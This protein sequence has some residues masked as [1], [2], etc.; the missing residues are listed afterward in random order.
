[1][2][3]GRALLT[4]LAMATLAL[5]SGTTYTI[6]GIDDVTAPGYPE[7]AGT[8]A[9]G[10]NAS[11]Q[12]AGEVDAYDVDQT[13]LLRRGVRWS[14]GVTTPLDGFP[15]FTFNS[16]QG[17][18]DA[19][20][21]VGISG[22][23]AVRWDGTTVTGLGFLPG[24]TFSYANGINNSNV[25]V[26]YADDTSGNMRAVTFSGG[27][28]TALNLPGTG[29]SL[30][31]AVSNSGIIVGESSVNPD[32]INPI[33]F[34][35]SN[36]VATQISLF[37]GGTRSYA[38]GVND[39]GTVVGFGNSVLGERGFVAT[40]NSPMSIGVLPGFTGS[41]ARAINNFGVVVGSVSKP[42]EGRAVIFSGGVLTDLNSLLPS[43]SGWTL[44]EATGINDAGQ[45]T[46]SGLFDDGVR[47]FVLTPVP[48]PATM[49]ALGLGV[50]ALLRRRK[51][52]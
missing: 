49:T 18:N 31:N 17:I 42:G 25:I 34:R 23:E 12:V 51:A 24:G 48:E 14:N 6:Q 4:S 7:P 20:V 44:L 15:G 22:A 37:G 36:G 47:G 41:R 21:V 43:G 33:A 3:M 16:G 32:G 52:A 38:L 1:M 46:G 29:Y 45:I 50:L 5:S 27:V 11:G 9:Y 26:G 19:G 8:R 40:G 10:I 13:E 30:A 2:N 39:A 28:A 35:Y